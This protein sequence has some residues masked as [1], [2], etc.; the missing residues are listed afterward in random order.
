MVQMNIPDRMKV[1]INFDDTSLSEAARTLQPL[2][3]QKANYFCCLLG[4]DPQV[5]VFGCGETVS[6]ALIDWEAN[7]HKRIISYKEGDEVA[8]FII[9]RL[10]IAN[11]GLE[12]Q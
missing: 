8:E 10:N 11:N 4:P 1:K 6:K 12:K 7:I 9:T 3:F 2:I 5:G